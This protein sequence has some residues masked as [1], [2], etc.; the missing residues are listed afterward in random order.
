GDE[1]AGRSDRA[2]R[3]LSADGRVRLEEVRDE[4]AALRAE[5]R[6]PVGEFLAEVIRRTGLLA[7]LQAAP[8]AERAMAT[9][10]NLAA[11]LDEVHAFAPLEGEVTL[12]AFLDYVATV[13]ESDRPEWSPVQ[14]SDEDSV[15]VMTIHQAKGLEFDTVFVPGFAKEILPDAR[16]QQNPAEKGKS[17]DFDLR[18]DA[19]ILPKFSDNLKQF[20]FALRD[21]AMIEERRTC[22]VALT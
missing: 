12:R 10:R 8:D 14:P 3:P 19:D 20:W 4:L 11:F 2:G 22:Y 21:Q 1:V 16:V 6:R 18:G 15:K 17:L 7:E 13:E 5:A 9:Q